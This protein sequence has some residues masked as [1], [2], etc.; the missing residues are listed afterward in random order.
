MKSA[1]HI[2][3]VKFK[4]NTRKTIRY[5]ESNNSQLNLF[6]ILGRARVTY[7]T[8]LGEGVSHACRQALDLGIPMQ[9]LLLASCVSGC[10]LSVRRSAARNCRHCAGP[11]VHNINGSANGP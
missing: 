10:D 1:K 6:P 2:L 11:R 3:Y 8:C 5:K 4:L 7:I 9:Q